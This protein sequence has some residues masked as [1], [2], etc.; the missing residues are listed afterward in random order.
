LPAKDKEDAIIIPTAIFGL[1]GVVLL[2][3]RYW[4]FCMAVPFL[5]IAYFCF[6]GAVGLRFTVHVGNIASLGI[7]FLILCVL[8]FLVRKIF[9]KEKA[10]HSNLVAKTSWA[11]WVLL[12]AL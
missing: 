11:V 8:T 2:M 5:A 12:E 4:E 1:L 7:V 10:G 3:L 9:S 6:Q